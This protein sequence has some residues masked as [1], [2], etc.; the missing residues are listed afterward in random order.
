VD[1]LLLVLV[2][3]AVAGAFVAAVAEALSPNERPH[4]L[5]TGEE[6]VRRA[7]RINGPFDRRAAMELRRR[8]LEDLRRHEAVRRHLESGGATRDREVTALLAVVERT[9]RATRHEIADVEMW[10]SRRL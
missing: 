3:C 5:A 10:L 8:L 9:A 7:L 6:R 4:P 2:G 1:V